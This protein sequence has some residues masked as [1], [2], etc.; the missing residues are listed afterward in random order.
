MFSVEVQYL[1]LFQ[2]SAKY[3]F[4]GIEKIMSPVPSQ[5]KKRR[6]SSEFLPFN[7]LQRP[8]KTNYNS[9]Q[10]PREQILFKGDRINSKI[11]VERAVIREFEEHR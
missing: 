1:R 8:S 7:I 9:L 11:K 3:L 2:Q 6:T 10:I 4:S 5:T